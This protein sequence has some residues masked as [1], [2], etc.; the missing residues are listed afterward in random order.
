MYYNERLLAVQARRAS[1][2]LVP[3]GGR[4]G[5]FRRPNLNEM[6]QP[7]YEGLEKMGLPI[8]QDL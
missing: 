4:I 1:F 5:L 8:R 7:D 6:G 3:P 2:C